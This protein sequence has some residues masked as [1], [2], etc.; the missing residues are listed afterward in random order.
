[1]H[2]A[3]VSV[4]NALADC[5]RVSVDLQLVSELKGV[6]NNKYLP[7]TS[8]YNYFALFCH[9]PRYLSFGHW[10]TITNAEFYC[11]VLIMLIDLVRLV[12]HHNYMQR[13]GS[14][15]ALMLLQC[16]MYHLQQ[17]I[18][19][20]RSTCR[21]SHFTTTDCDTAVL[22]RIA[23]STVTTSRIWKLYRSLKYNNVLQRRTVQQCS[24]KNAHMLCTRHMHTALVSGPMTV[25]QSQASIQCTHTGCSD[26]ILS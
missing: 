4:Q 26:P 11:C 21:S 22:V 13:T 19:A 15:L 1:M 17:A 10:F 24:V 18:L 20:F 2:L 23:N 25:Y 6:D 8:I 14:S 3:T 5:I 16:I 7:W 9:T 12:H